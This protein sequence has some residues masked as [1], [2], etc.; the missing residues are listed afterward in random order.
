MH[1][2]CVGVGSIG[3]LVAFHLRRANPAP[4]HAFTIFIRP[5]ASRTSRPGRHYNDGIYVES[6]GIRRKIRGFEFEI[7]DPS[8]QHFR[9]LSKQQHIPFLSKSVASALPSRKAS[10]SSSIISSLIVTNKA[11]SVRNAIEEVRKRLDASSTIVLLQN[12]MGIYDRLV[13]EIFPDPDTRP[14]FIIGSTTHGVWSKRPFDIV[15]AGIGKFTFALVPDPF[16]RRDFETVGP[17]DPVGQ[18]NPDAVSI[19]RTHHRDP[20]FFSLSETTRAFLRSKDLFP[21]WKTMAEMDVVLRSKLAVNACVGPLTAMLDCPNGGL[22]ASISA[23]RIIRGICQEAEAVFAAEAEEKTRTQLSS[24]VSLPSVHPT[25]HIALSRRALEQQVMTVALSTSRNW[26]SMHQ[27]VKNG[28]TTEIE[29]INGHLTRTAKRL[30]VATPINN[31]LV[32]FIRMKSQ[33]PAN[34]SK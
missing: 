33:I 8:I 5:Q 10:E 29:Y 13:S 14:N 6:Y 26:S 2:H 28:K 4:G 27:D 22:Y 12:G 34:M 18:L 7:L 9:L 20:K 25:W 19:A 16:K 21:E 30:G 3:A 31:M 17:D 24:D 32:D 1:F 11:P 23:H 15:H